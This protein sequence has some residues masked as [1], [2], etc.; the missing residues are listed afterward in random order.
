MVYVLGLEFLAQDEA[1]LILRN[2]LFVSMSRSLAWVH[3]SA[4]NTMD[5]PFY[6][7]VRQSLSIDDTLT[8]TYCRPTHIIDDFDPH[9][10]YDLVDEAEDRDPA[11]ALNSDE[12]EGLDQDEAA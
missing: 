1:N 7:E 9:L 12:V 10:S 5:S 4:L 8:F 11:E 3:L 2:Q 6:R